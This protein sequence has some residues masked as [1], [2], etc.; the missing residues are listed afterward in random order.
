MVLAIIGGS[1]TAW[2]I[3]FF[4]GAYIMRRGY[5]KRLKELQGK[6]AEIDKQLG[7][8]INALEQIKSFKERSDVRS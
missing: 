6:L 2:V 7:T 5:G 3:G 8:Q 4:T 1:V